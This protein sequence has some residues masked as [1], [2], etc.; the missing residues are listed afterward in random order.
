MKFYSAFDVDDKSFHFS[1]TPSNTTLIEYQFAKELRLAKRYT[2]SH[3]GAEQ[4]VSIEASHSK[5]WHCWFR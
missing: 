5:R 2:L 1:H 4:M 3:T